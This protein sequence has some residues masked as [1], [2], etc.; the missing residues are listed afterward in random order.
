MSDG[1][2]TFLEAQLSRFDAARS[3]ITQ[4][5]ARNGSMQNRVD[6]ILAAHADQTIALEEL[7]GKRTDADM[8]QAITDLQLSQVAMQASAQVIS[9]LR[10]SS[11]LYLLRN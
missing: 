9:S 5:A 8:A 4:H 10:E 11:L 6:T 7:V 1:V 3:D 2:R